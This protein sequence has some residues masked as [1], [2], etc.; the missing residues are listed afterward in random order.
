MLRVVGVLGGSLAVAGVVLLATGYTN[1]GVL[2][3]A[4]SSIPWIG[5][6]CLH[7]VYAPAPKPSTPDPPPV[8]TVVD[9]DPRPVSQND[10]LP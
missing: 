5:Y 4:T 3:I 6:A 7:Q 8:V 2:C 10:L 1:S 9:E